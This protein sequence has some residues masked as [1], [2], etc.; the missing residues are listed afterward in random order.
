MLHSTMFVDVLHRLTLERD[1]KDEKFIDL[2]LF[3]EAEYLVTRDRDL[4]DLATAVPP[5]GSQI[6]ARSLGLN[7]LDPV[8]FL[9]RFVRQEG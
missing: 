2:A 6:D 7:I 1:P 9:R 5:E 8:A 4:L 3:A